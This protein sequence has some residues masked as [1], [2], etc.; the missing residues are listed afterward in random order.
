MTPSGVGVRALPMHVRVPE[1]ELRR[2]G[3]LVCLPAALRAFA[4][5]QEE[6]LLEAPDAAILL[7]RLDEAFPG[8]R[9]RVVDETGRLRPF[10]NLFV[11]EDLVR[12]PLSQV[13]LRAGDVVH[14]LPS[15]AGG[16]HG[17]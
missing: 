9:E 14:I 5:G 3:V 16:I 12:A 6:V 8:I 10:V 7:Q 11:N 4:G 17:G 2:S 13:S 15:V 1:G